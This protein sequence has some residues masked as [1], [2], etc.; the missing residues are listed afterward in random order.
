[1]SDYILDDTQREFNERLALKNL[2]AMTVTMSG[3]S[4]GRM[5]MVFECPGRPDLRG[6]PIECATWAEMMDAAVTR[7]EQLY[8]EVAK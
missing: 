6:Q 4:I 8:G 5:F 2:P 1:M 3:Y 7:A